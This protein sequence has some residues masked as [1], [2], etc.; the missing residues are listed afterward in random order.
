MSPLQQSWWSSDQGPHIPYTPGGTSIFN[1]KD[2]PNRFR[3]VVMGSSP[4][5]VDLLRQDRALCLTP[6]FPPGQTPS[7]PYRV[8]IASDYRISVE[9]WAARGWPVLPQKVDIG[10]VN[11]LLYYVYRWE[12]RCQ[13]C[14]AVCKAFTI[15]YYDRDLLCSDC[16]AE[17]RARPDFQVAVATLRQAHLVGNFTF[18]GLDHV[19]D[20]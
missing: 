11:A 6:I 13:R 2:L 8:V 12:G 19:E 7:A 4:F 14:G 18:D 5:P 16:D 10:S 20:L 17:E 3:A 1:G 15:S 9:Q